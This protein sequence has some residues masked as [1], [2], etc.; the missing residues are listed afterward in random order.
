MIPFNQPAT[1]ANALDC[2][3]AVY[4]AIQEFRICCRENDD[5]AVFEDEEEMLREF[6]KHLRQTMNRLGLPMPTKKERKRFAGILEPREHID[7]ACGN[8]AIELKYKPA[9]FELPE[10]GKERQ[11]KGNPKFEKAKHVTGNDGVFNDL[12]KMRLLIGNDRSGITVG[13]AVVLTSREFAAGAEDALRGAGLKSEGEWTNHQ[14]I[15]TRYFI[16]E[17]KKS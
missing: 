3:P 7:I 16:L 13:Y 1:V 6:L 15:L 5:L 11:R 4:S 2:G 14:G 17:V 12:R 8:V 10:Q 9:P